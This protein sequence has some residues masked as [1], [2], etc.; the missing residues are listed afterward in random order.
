MTVKHPRLLA[1]IV[2]EWLAVRRHQSEIALVLREL[3]DGDSTAPLEFYN[4]SY[5]LLLPMAVAVLEHALIGLRDEQAFL[6]RSSGL[7]SLMLASRFRI[8]WVDYE[9][10]EEIRVTRN[11]LVHEGHVP[12]YH[13]IFSSLDALEDE[14]IAWSIL[15]GHTKYEV[16]VRLAGE[17]LRDYTIRM[18][19]RTGKRCSSNW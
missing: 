19:N 14:W 8:P 3:P 7:K 11:A 4:R 13:E 1:D 18:Q 9:R 12:V 17:D 16:A 10:V 5:A 2:D 15:K 6:C